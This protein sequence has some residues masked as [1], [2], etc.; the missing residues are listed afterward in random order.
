MKVEDILAIKGPTGY[1]R[2]RVTLEK[3]ETTPCAASTKK[4]W[5]GP[6]TFVRVTWPDGGVDETAETA[7]VSPKF[8][9]PG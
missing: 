1:C 9:V 7:K 2:E 8:N 4:Q 6:G 5:M 3:G